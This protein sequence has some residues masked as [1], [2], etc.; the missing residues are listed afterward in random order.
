ML[1]FPLCSNALNLFTV[2][3]GVAVQVSKPY[4]R[5][6]SLEG[7]VNCPVAVVTSRQHC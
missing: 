2:V 5:I 1:H 4:N 3:D 7:E 6:G